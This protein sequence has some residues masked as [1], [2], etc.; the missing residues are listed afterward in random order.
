[1]PHCAG[2]RH[3]GGAGARSGTRFLPGQG[4]GGGGVPGPEMEDAVRRHEAE[5]ERLA[6]RLVQPSH[7]GARRTHRQPRSGLAHP[8]HGHSLARKGRGQ[9]HSAD[10]ASAGRPV[11]IGGS[12]GF[13]ASGP[14]ARPARFGN[15]RQRRGFRQVRAMRGG[16][17][18]RIRRMKAVLSFCL[19]DLL[20]SRFIAAYFLF[21]L[22]AGYSLMHYAPTS[23]SGFGALL[24]LVLFLAPLSSSVFGTLYFYQSRGFQELMLSQPVSRAALLTGQGAALRFALCAAL[25]LGLCFPTLA[26]G[27]LGGLVLPFLAAFMGDGV[28]LHLC[29]LALAFL[30]A[31]T[32][33]DRLRGF[34]AS[35]VL[36]L[37][38]V[39]FYDGALLFIVTRFSDYPL[40]RFVIGAVLLN[41]VD[42]E[43]ILVLMQLDASVLLGYTGSVF[44][45]FFGTGTGLA[46][47]FAAMA[48]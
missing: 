18:G 15:S 21:H 48:L 10:Y 4:V 22:A 35:L 19:K 41:P 28:L 44:R 11:G 16:I 13:P 33:E 24:S 25:S 1:K 45:R 23:S 26:A 6:G 20:R 14:A 17:A 12:P 34:S 31:L 8:P 5:G 42:L 9:D 29:F 36:W 38:L 3:L 7:A 32:M 40:D 47:S 30:I 27:F 39:F 37:F 43:R 46:V 2:N